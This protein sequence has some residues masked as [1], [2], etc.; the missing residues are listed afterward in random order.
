M[1]NIKITFKKSK[2]ERGCPHRF[3]TVKM[4]RKKFATIMPPN[5][6]NRKYWNIQIAI[7][8]CEYE[9]FEKWE[10]MMPDVDF[11]SDEEAMAWMENNIEEIQ[12]KYKFH[13]FED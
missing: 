4:K 2:Y 7:V 10:W 1:S 9:N 8:K 11:K 12:S 5:Y 6:L 13:F 3:V